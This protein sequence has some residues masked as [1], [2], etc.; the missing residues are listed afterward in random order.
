[1]LCV[2]VF[3]CVA[4]ANKYCLEK[5]IGRGSFGDVY[6]AVSK[7]SGRPVAIKVVNLEQTLDEMHFL[8]Q[9]IQFLSL[10]RSPYV[11]RY[12]KSFIE[13]TS[14]WIVME[15]CGAGSVADMLRRFKKFDEGIT[16]RVIK[17]VVHGLAYLH[18]QKIVHRDVKL[19]NVLIAADGTIKLADFG[20][21]G[22][23]TVTQ[24][25]KSTFVGTPY[26]MAPEVI[27]RSKLGYNEK[28]DIWLTGITAIELIN[29]EPPLSQHDPMKMVFQIPIL[30]P[31]LLTGNKYSVELKSF[32]WQC[33]VK[34]PQ[35][36][37]SSKQL[38]QHKFLSL[39]ATKEDF[40]KLLKK[41]KSGILGRYRNKPGNIISN[42]DPQPS[43]QW[44]FLADSPR[45]DEEEMS[46]QASELLLAQPTPETA[47]TTPT[48]QLVMPIADY[49]DCVLYCLA[50]V[51]SRARRATIKD[52][53]IPLLSHVRAIEADHPGFCRALIREMAV[54]H[55][56]LM[57]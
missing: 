36:R 43:I 38:M 56:K 9:E 49:C 55:S 2:S 29:G 15:F 13:G 31:P 24:A 12:L 21:S 48:G 30:E 18:E 52:K 42:K 54:A 16:A 44:N 53:V 41:R 32:V 37:S 4:M 47:A 20:V 3:H 11:V 6:K 51:C 8:V 46:S 25:R 1:M 22:N 23:I 33:L 19:A 34:N 50:S 7:H 26:W 14:M 17:Y 10:M 40:C 5:C 45:S 27:I 57:Q 28:A 39:A 35:K